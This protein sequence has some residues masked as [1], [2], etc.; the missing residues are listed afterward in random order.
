MIDLNNHLLGENGLEV[1]LD[2]ALEGCELAWRDGVREI[3]LTCRCHWP[4]SGPTD[5]LMLL[6]RFEQRLA[7]LRR[8]VELRFNRDVHSLSDSQLKL[9][10]G[11]EW[12][13]TADLPKVLAD[14]PVVPSINGSSYLLLGFPSLQPVAQAE[15]VIDDL[16]RDGWRPVIAHPECSRVLRRDRNLL[17]RLFNQG[18]LLQLDARS[19]LGGYGR[20]VEKFA[21][22]L[23]EQNQVHFIATRAN[24]RTRGVVS[25]AEACQRAAR[26]IGSHAA[27]LLV[28]DNPLEVLMQKM[29]RPAPVSVCQWPTLEAALS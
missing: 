16:Q 6:Q 26:L 7:D 18:A 29:E 9:A 4:Q 12:L 15:G 23:L 27:R 2:K 19:I 13:L 22:N 21:L 14:L 5:S 20:E 17:T 28:S 25:L 10:G 24:H 1:S 11:Y 8:A 3:V